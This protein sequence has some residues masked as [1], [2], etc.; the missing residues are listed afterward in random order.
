MGSSRLL[1][2]LKQV[3]HYQV[4]FRVI[5]RKSIFEEGPTVSP[6]LEIESADLKL[7]REEGFMGSCYH[8]KHYLSDAVANVQNSNITVYEFKLQLGN[9]VYFRTIFISL[10]MG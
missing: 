1:G 10:A 5:L 3:P 9:D 2:S 8:I 7:Q 6:L 4:Q